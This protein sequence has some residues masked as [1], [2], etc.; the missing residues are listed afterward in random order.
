MA[1]RMGYRRGG[2]AVIERMRFFDVYLGW[3]LRKRHDEGATWPIA[4][5]VVVVAVVVAYKAVAIP[6]RLLRNFYWPPRR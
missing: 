2:G 5:A 6:A 4:A 1:G 3:W